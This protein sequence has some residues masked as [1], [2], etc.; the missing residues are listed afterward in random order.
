MKLLSNNPEITFDDILLLPQL[1]Q[2]DYE[3]DS[4]VD[5]KTKISKKLSIDIPVTSSPMPGV[6]EEEMAIAIG[7]MGGLGFIHSFQ[8]PSRQLEQI[9]K[10]KKQKVK[11]AAT[12]T[13]DLSKTKLQHIE[14]LL[15]LK[16]DLICIYTYH[17]LNIPTIKF[18]NKVRKKFP[19]AQLNTGPIATKKAVQ[20][21]SEI[22]I[23]SLNVGIGPGSHC[24]TRL[25]TGVG[26][27]QLSAIKECAST[28][29]KYKVP[30]IAEGGLKTPGDISKALAFGANAVMIGGMFSGTA[31]APG[32][33]IHKN[34]KKYKASWGMCSNTA[35][36]YQ[37]LNLLGLNNSFNK[38]KKL[39]KYYLRINPNSEQIEKL[40]EEGIEGL[41]E[42]KGS[43][44]PIIKRLAD[45][46]RRS[47]WYQGA[48][49][50]EELQKKAIAVLITN[51][52]V[53]ENKPR[54]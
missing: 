25:V 42:Y 43:V 49:N 1:S 29:E 32:E 15:K 52:T 16:T 11:V 14:N 46:T 22:G 4:K 2:Y 39:L 27:P 17:S 5:I 53:V 24:T 19:N 10:A 45:G 30:I 34:Q 6:T 28:A 41:I 33:I 18:I 40:F 8:S 21:L 7:K 54:I 37:H 13:P 3:E 23:D 20:T 47:Q 31:E 51:N 36:T 9:K 38:I 44:K 50:I 26:R 48:E 35:M 12:I